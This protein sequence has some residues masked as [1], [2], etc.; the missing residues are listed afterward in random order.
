MSISAISAATRLLQLNPSKP[1]IGQDFQGLAASLQ[2][3][4]LNGAQ[5][6][7]HDLKKLLST[8]A[9]IQSAI[10]GNGGILQKDFQ[11]LG[12]DLSNGD[13]NAAQKD[14]SQLQKDAQSAI[15][16]FSGAG[17]AGHHHHHHQVDADDSN[18]KAVNA[19]A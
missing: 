15:A 11:Q 13:L 6:A 3:G 19:I 2:S 14:L 9:N 12:Q 7:Y 1:T 18:V 16:Q 4:D 5:K 10:Q 8:N 17:K